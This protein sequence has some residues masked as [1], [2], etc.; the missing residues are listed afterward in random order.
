MSTYYQEMKT[1]FPNRP[2]I[3]RPTWE[4]KNMVKAL[5]SMPALN[6]DEENARLASVRAELVSRGMRQYRTEKI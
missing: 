1:K 2:Y 5:E 3:G 6:T 4:L